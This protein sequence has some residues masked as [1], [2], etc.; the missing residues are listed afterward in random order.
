MTVIDPQMVAEHRRHLGALG[1]QKLRQLIDL[2]EQARNIPEGE[3]G[4]L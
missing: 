3:E 2:L 4:E 1:E